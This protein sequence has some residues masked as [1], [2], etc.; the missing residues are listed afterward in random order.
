MYIYRALAAVALERTDDCQV[1]SPF[2]QSV[3]R[4]SRDTV[5]DSQFVVILNYILSRSN[6]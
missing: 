1:V 3:D 6:G 2:T 5:F 4:L